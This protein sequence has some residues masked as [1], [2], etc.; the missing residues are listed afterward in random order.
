M[1]KYNQSGCRFM[2]PFPICIEQYVGCSV[3]EKRE[4]DTQKEKDVYTQES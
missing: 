2:F 1:T 3:T 4:K